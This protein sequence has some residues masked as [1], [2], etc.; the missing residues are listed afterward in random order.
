[1]GRLPAD[2]TMQDLHDAFKRFGDIIGVNM[3]PRQQ[4]PQQS[5]G[6]GYMEGCG[7]GVVNFSN[8]VAARAALQMMQGANIGGSV[9]EI[10]PLGQRSHGGP[11]GGP[12]PTMHHSGPPRDHHRRGGGDR[13]RPI[14]GEGNNWVCAECDN[15]NWAFRKVCNRCKA[16]LKRNG[17]TGDR[18]RS[19]N[20]GGGGGG[21]SPKRARHHSDRES[22]REPQGNDGRHHSGSDDSD[23]EGRRGRGRIRNERD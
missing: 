10:R 20:S 17:S 1:M 13:Q 9:I 2:A 4:Q 22:D 16:P 12:P 21:N 5:P 6:G 15:V 18:P 19:G 8:A 23:E 7:C 11:P 3:Q 14:A